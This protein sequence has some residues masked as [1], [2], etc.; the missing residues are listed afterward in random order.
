MIQF[1]APLVL[2]LLLNAATWPGSTYQW[3][4][5][6]TGTSFNVTATGTYWVNVTYNGCVKRDTVRIKINTITRYLQTK[7][8]CGNDTVVLNSGR[9]LGETY[10]WNNGETSPSLPVSTPGIYINTVNWNGCIISDTFN[11]IAAKAPFSNT[12]TTICYPFLPFSL[13]AATPGAVSYLWQNNATTPAFTVNVPGTYWVRVW[14]GTCYLRDTV[15]VL[16][17][18]PAINL[19]SV[20]TICNGQTYT[21]PWGV[22][23]KY[24]RCLQGYIMQQV[25]IVSGEP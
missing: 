7:Y 18:V 17:S 13:N 21:F 6:S 1:F 10:F 15:N 12:D 24:S 20:A 5:N 8:L 2:S 3:Q 4:N 14:N 19:N 22:T 16:E 11:V 25:A 9:G 23:R